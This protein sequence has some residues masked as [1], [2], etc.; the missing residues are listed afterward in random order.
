[1][2]KVIQSGLYVAVDGNWGDAE[3]MAIIDDRN[4]EQSDYRMID[5]ATD[6]NK[7]DVAEAIERWINAG[8]PEFENETEENLADLIL[9]HF[10][11]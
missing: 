6:S 9:G 10:G 11:Q 1:M 8:R 3:G 5:E 2:S 7:V 4:W